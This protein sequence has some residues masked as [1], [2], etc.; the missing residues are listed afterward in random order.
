MTALSILLFLA[1]AL[2]VAYLYLL[3][4]AAVRLRTTQP[5]AAP[6]CRFAITIAAYDEETVI[7]RAV[8][9]LR[10]Q[11][12]PPDLYDIYIVADHCSDETAD[13]ARRAGAICWERN[14][15]LRGGKGAALAWL[16]EKVLA[17]EIAYD[18]VVV[19]DADTVAH[20][21]FLRTMDARLQQGDSVIQGCHRIINYRDGWFPAL[22]WAMYIVDNRFQNLGRANLGWSAK[23]MGDS[24]CFRADIIR[25][26]GWGG[27]LTDDYEFRQRLLLEGIKIQYEPNAIGYG[28][29]AIN[30][31]IARAQ[32]ARWLGGVS[33]V[34]HRYAMEM[35][36]KGMSQFDTGLLDGAAQSIFPS[37][38]T[39]VLCAFGG[40]LL[41]AALPTLFSSTTLI[42][43]ASLLALLA[44]Y[45]LY[46]LAL[47]QAPWRAYIALL[48]GPI[49][50]IWRT[51]I[52][53]L[54]RV[55]PGQLVWVRTP[56]SSKPQLMSNNEPK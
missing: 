38:S 7:G 33:R 27:G 8:S 24:I 6:R 56:R 16:F 43:W 4:L 55:G 52:A 9:N 53:V 44:I 19:F 49:F 34:S 22:T 35:L 36:K 12:Y 10:Q 5:N 50:I 20:S 28:E 42:L 39:L 41:Q 47:E 32:R 13:R 48:L 54:A 11:D 46:G 30:W 1:L 40:L 15:G 23:N 14:E 25:R 31:K 3:G 21:E 51:S 18:A 37:Y 2:P 26:L 45:P 29:A 17:A